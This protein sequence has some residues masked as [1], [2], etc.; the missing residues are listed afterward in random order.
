MND[1]RHSLYEYNELTE[2]R[3]KSRRSFLRI[4]EKL[5]GTSAEFAK[6]QLSN[7]RDAGRTESETL[8]SGNQLNYSL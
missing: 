3:L 4:F 6:H 1:N 7:R 2:Q 8:P 5:K